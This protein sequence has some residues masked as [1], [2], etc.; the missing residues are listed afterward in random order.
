MLKVIFL[1]N[2][3]APINFF[4]IEYIVDSYNNNEAVIVAKQAFLDDGHKKQY[5]NELIISEARIL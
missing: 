5:Y 1:P 3:K 2:K 4:S